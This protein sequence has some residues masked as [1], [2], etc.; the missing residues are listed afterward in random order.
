MVS[1]AM[2]V[3]PED[4]SIAATMKCNDQMA[5]FKLHNHL[6]QECKL[7]MIRWFGKSMFEDLH[8]NGLPPNTVTAK[9]LL[10]HL[11]KAHSQLCDKR[12]HLEQSEKDLNSPCNAKKPV[13]TCFMKLQEAQNDTKPLGKP[14][15]PEIVMNEALNQFAKQCGEDA[16]KAERNGTRRATKVGQHSRIGGR[17]NSIS[18]NQ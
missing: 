2:P 6:M 15:T 3:K 5:L 16:R 12:Q 4:C 17:A 14:C 7:K 8:K 11:E 13:E 9:Q 10:L 1:P 18:G